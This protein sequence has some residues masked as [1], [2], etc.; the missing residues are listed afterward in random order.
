MQ[1]FILPMVSK[2]ERTGLS[3]KPARQVFLRDGLTVSYHLFKPERPCLDVMCM[4]C[5]F[6]LMDRYQT[7]H[8]SHTHSIEGNYWYDITYD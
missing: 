2:D 6:L 4:E 8:C 7:F 5:E 1:N 3:Q